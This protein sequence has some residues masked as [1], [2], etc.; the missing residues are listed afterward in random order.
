MTIDEVRK[1]YTAQPFRPF[2]LHL[3]DGREFKIDHPEFISMSRVGRTVAVA[4][5]DGT[6]EIID[7]LHVVSLSM[8]DG[9]PA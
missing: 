5:I 6:F 2:C 3:D 9:Q 8:G 4:D 7:L 1:C